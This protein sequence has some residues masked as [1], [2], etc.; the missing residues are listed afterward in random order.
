[1]VSAR[2]TTPTPMIERYERR[3]GK[4]NVTRIMNLLRRK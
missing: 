2:V 4:L 1:M 3:A